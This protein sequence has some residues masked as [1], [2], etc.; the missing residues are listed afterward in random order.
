MQVL[1]QTWTDKTVTSEQKTTVEYVVDLQNSIEQT[2]NIA[3]ENLKK[4][5]RRQA[6]YFNHK[7]V[8]RMIEVGKKVLLLR[9][10]K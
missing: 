1:R 4:A 10:T 6:K 2:C 7:T 8:P 3:K 5:A 9:P